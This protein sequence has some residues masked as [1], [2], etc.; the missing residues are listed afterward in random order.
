MEIA[1]G[2]FERRVRIPVPFDREGV[3]AQVIDGF[4]TV[5]LP[6]RSTEPQ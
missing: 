1:S 5:R 3:S 4:L 2:P 6:K